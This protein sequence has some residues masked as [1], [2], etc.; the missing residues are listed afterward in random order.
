MAGSEFNHADG[1]KRVDN[2]Y[3]LHDFKSG[4]HLSFVA[5]APTSYAKEE[6]FVMGESGLLRHWPFNSQ[7]FAVSG[8]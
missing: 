5:P 2:F 4:R 1:S 7:T 6:R 3:E 8:H